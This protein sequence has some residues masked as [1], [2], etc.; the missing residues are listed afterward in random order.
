MNDYVTIVNDELGWYHAYNDDAK[1][2]N[3]LT[4]YII[5][6]DIE[7][8]YRVG[9][10]LISINKVKRLLR[11]YGIDYKVDN[12]EIYR[13]EHNNYKNYSNYDKEELIDMDSFKGTFTIQFND[14]E[15]MSFDIGNNINPY[16][17]I[18]RFVIFN[19]VGTSCEK[20]N[21]I[22]TII[23]KKIVNR[24]VNVLEKYKNEFIKKLKKYGGEGFIHGTSLDNLES[25]FKCG[26]IYSR[27]S[28]IDNNINFKDSA[29]EEILNI[30]S[31]FVKKCARLYFRPKTPTLIRMYNSG[32]NDL[33]LFI[34]DYKLL[35]DYHLG[36][37]SDKK[38]MSIK[39]R[40]YDIGD[41]T[42]MYN[43][44]NDFKY[45]YT[46]YGWV[47]KSSEIWDYKSAELLIPDYIDIKYIKEIVFPNNILYNS[48]INNFSGWDVKTS[49]RPDLFG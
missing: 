14:E 11:K 3:K 28:C 4:N 31:S 6:K 18:V 16:A 44:V 49:I 25:I 37:I 26:K 24:E 9:F 17:D 13:N 48:F 35:I 30:T 36:K 15:P 47:D 19:E 22:V 8:R 34:L 7:G 12:E 10:P 45:D 29:N 38:P 20:N 46:F 5:T 33:V 27:Q 41:T 2:I 23:D 42:D 32:K 40:S 1:C 43:V 39:S 21:E